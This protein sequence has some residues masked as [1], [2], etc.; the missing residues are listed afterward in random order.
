MR[1]SLL[2]CL[3]S[4]VTPIASLSA[5]EAEPTAFVERV[6]PA[7]YYD[8][9]RLFPEQFSTSNELSVLRTSAG[10]PVSVIAIARGGESDGFTLMLQFASA[11]TPG[12]WLRITE[13]L[14]SAVGQQVLR[15]VELTL[16]YQVTL[17]RFKHVVS[18]TDS[19][20]WIFQKLSDGRSAAG[21]I[22]TEASLNHPR[23]SLFIEGLLEHLQQLSGKA[24][25]ERAALLQKIDRTATD[26]IVAASR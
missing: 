26:L 6:K 1:C 15:A 17:S 21:V 2:F 8:A 4:F 7:D 9:E 16:H 10:K 14:E 20:L 25:E 13:D 23:A 3:V 19:D 11:D 12:G 18:K 24:G 5:V 22:T